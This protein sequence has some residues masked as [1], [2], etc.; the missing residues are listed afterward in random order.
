MI[1]GPARDRNFTRK[2][3]QKRKNS[4]AAPEKEHPVSLP[5]IRN[6]QVKPIY[7]INHIMPQR[8]FR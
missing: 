2:K 5:A 3:L 7:S 6:L 8:I 4:F 1:F